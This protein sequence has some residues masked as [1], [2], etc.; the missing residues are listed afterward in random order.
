MVRLRKRL[1]HKKKY[2]TGKERT[3]IEVHLIY[4][5]LEQ[6]LEYDDYT[7]KAQPKTSGANH[8]C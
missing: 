8:T 5:I 1:P 6:T 7:T 3:H 4:R 2:I